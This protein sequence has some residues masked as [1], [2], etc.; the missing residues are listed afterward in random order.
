MSVRVVAANSSDPQ[1]TPALA[2]ALD[3]AGERGWAV[4]PVNLDKTPACAGGFKSA[5]KDPAIIRRLFADGGPLIGVAAGEA[6][7]VDALDLDP[8]NGSDAW[9]QDHLHHLS[10][11]MT[12]RTR[13]GGEHYIFKHQP[14]LRCSVAALAVGCDIRAD[15][16]YFIYWPGYG[17]SYVNDAEPQHWPQ[18]ILDQFGTLK[19]HRAANGRAHNPA[20]PAPPSV[21][22]VVRLIDGLPNPVEAGRDVYLQVLSGARGCILSLGKDPGDVIR[23][24]AIAWAEK[25]EGGSRHDERKAWEKGWANNGAVFAG[26][27][28]LL[29]VARKLVPGFVDETAGYE[30]FNSP[31]DEIVEK[32]VIKVESGDRTPIVSAAEDALISGKV[33]LYQQAGVLVR[34][35]LTPHHGVQVQSVNEV[36]LRELMGRTAKWTKYNEQTDN[37][38]VITCPLEMAKAFLSRGLLEW[39]VPLLEG[40]VGAPT[41]RSDGS[42]LACHGYD[43]DT[44]LFVDLTSCKASCPEAPTY[45]D[46]LAAVRLLDDLLSDFPFV[47]PV[48]RSVALTAFLTAAIR[49]SLPTAPMFAF[50]AP[51]AGTGKSLLVDLLSTV[52]T[53]KPAYGFTWSADPHENP[54]ALD[55]ALL[56]GTANINIDN[57]QAPLGGDRLNQILTQRSATLR[58]LGESRTVEVT[59][60]ALITANGNNLSIQSDLT[61]RTMLCSM[62]ANIERPENRTF[63][64]PNLLADVQAKWGDYLSSALTILRAYHVAGRPNPPKPLGSFVEWSNWVRG[65]IIWLGYADPVSSQEAVREVDPIRAAVAAVLG[66]WDQHIGD[67]RVTTSQV[68]QASLCQAEFQASLLAVAGTGKNVNTQRLAK[69]LQSH[70]NQRIGELSIITAGKA[71]G[72]V[73]TWVLSGGRL[74]VED[75]V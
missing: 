9:R 44:K 48:D 22:A 75:S 16:G 74:F 31:L 19:L 38:L 18:E 24:A 67:K 32:P 65:A 66:Q 12:Y 60:A 23:D 64:T 57:V 72:N 47:T 50:T 20:K 6:S 34:V 45:E 27:S 49:R 46:A 53:G 70:K 21:G 14:G 8:R 25:W 41:L 73:Q 51:A 62:D 39:R 28:T 69:W 7:G 5:S 29:R 10:S 30:F 3:L 35:A 13:S 40:L 37:D 55:A 2:L 63:K 54:K 33:G 17:E 59:C 26:W 56:R 43:P 58:V 68:I 4:F 15:G 61:R 1:H 11:T 42:V 71:A 36:H 52:A